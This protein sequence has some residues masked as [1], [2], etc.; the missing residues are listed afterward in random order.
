MPNKTFDEYTYTALI[1]KYRY[2]LMGFAALWIYC[3]HDWSLMFSGVPF[4]GFLESFLKRIGFCGVDI[5]LF[6]SGM[7][8]YYSYNNRSLFSFYKN[9]MKRIL[10]PIL[11]T[12]VIRMI[13]ENWTLP[14]FLRNITGI[15]FFFENI[16][17]FLWFGIAI[18]T[19]YLLFP[20]YAFFL[21]NNNKPVIFTIVFTIIWTLLSAAFGHIIREDLYG[22][23]NM[24]PVFVIGA[25]FSACA[26][27][28]V[29]L[30]INNRLMI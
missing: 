5:F 10:F 21:S 29:F 15:S 8:L 17:A 3:N 23:L 1:S 19:L 14:E 20:V 24:I 22:F 12:A 13:L 7:G 11:F 9:R 26:E 30:N 27:K 6:L 16:Y 4:I 2:E 28:N 25:C 18:A